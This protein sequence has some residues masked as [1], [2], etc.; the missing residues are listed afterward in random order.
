LVSENFL[1][2]AK[3]NIEFLKGTLENNFNSG[4]KNIS[5]AF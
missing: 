4:D 1:T 2:A 5:V 3:A